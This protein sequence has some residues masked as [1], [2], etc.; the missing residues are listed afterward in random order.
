MPRKR[1]VVRGAV[2]GVGFRYFTRERAQSI[3]LSG[4]VR[5][6]ADGTV[7]VEAQG[8]EQ[9]LDQLIAMLNRGPGLARVRG[10]EVDDIPEEPTHR[11]FGVR[12]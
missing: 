5:N 7:L 9:E 6:Q 4:W 3:G 12:F 11:E 2:Q 1:I 8:E 10:L